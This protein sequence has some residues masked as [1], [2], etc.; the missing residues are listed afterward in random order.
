MCEQ[1]FADHGSEETE[2]GFGGIAGTYIDNA[3]RYEAITGYKRMLFLGHDDGKVRF[4]FICDED[5]FD[6]EENME[7]VVSALKFL[8]IDAAVEREGITAGGF[9]ICSD[10]VGYKDGRAVHTWE[11]SVR[12]RKDIGSGYVAV[13]RINPGISPSFLVGAIKYAFECRFGKSEWIEPCSEIEKI[14]V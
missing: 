12:R 6:R 7:L 14:S 10:D 13:D 8:D 4:L 5:R 3:E 1:L 9:R 11:M 2:L